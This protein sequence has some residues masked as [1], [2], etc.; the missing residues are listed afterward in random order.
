MTTYAIGDVQGCYDDLKRLLDHISFDPVED[1][2]W[3]TGDLINRG[4]KNLATLRLVRDLGPS[5]IVVQGNHDLHL[6]GVVFGGHKPNS[7]DT[8]EDIL[9]ADDCEELCHWVRTLP[10]IHTNEDYVLVHAGVPHIWTLEQAQS[11]AEEVQ[12]KIQGLDYV[13]FFTKMYGDQDRMWSDDLRGLARLRAITNY[14]SRMR[15]IAQSGQLEFKVKSS[16]TKRPSGFK[17]W[18]EYDTKFKQQILFGH[19][20]TL[21]GGTYRSQFHALDTGCVWG[22]NLTALRLNDQVRFEVSASSNIP[23]EK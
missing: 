9:R 22:G 3:F 23:I 19:W 1:C 2:L 13:E 11:L 20:S 10:L 4:P 5:A 17:P 16:P 7:R 14:L 8:F 12:T 18:F 21:D 6:L 15:F